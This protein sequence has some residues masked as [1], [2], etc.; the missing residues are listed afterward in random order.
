MVVDAPPR[1]G[2]AVTLSGALAA[3]ATGLCMLVVARHLVQRIPVRQPG[4]RAAAAVGRGS[5]LARRRRQ[6]HHARLLDAAFPEL[7]DLVVVSV[8][9][10]L[11]PADALRD[12]ATLV[13][14]PLRHALDAVE[15]RLSRGERFADALQALVEE[16]GPRA[17]GLVAT[18]VAT[19][20]HGL[21]LA[22]ALDRLADEARDHRRRLAEATARELPVRMSFPLV[23]CTLPSFALVAIVPLLV[24]ALSSLQPG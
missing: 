1:Q 3:L 10:G 6:R 20:R 19:D 17:L 7:L 14:P 24:G 23:L 21:P 2:R 22:P 13:E 8:Q 15:A 12:A 18:V 16:L 9:A 11:L 5:R 4:P